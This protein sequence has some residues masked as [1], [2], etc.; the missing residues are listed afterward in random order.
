MGIH[1]LALIVW[2]SEW[3]DDDN[4]VGFEIHFEESDYVHLEVYSEGVNL[5]MVDWMGGG[6]RLGLCRVRHH[7]ALG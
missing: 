6:V 5:S 2:V 3:L 4:W 1:Q 7:M